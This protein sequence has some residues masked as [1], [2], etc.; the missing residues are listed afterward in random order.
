M[1]YDS[2]RFLTALQNYQRE[3]GYTQTSLSYLLGFSRQHVHKWLTGK[4][5]V[6]DKSI[7]RICK[8]IG[9]RVSRFLP[10][11]VTTKLTS[12]PDDLDEQQALYTKYHENSRKHFHD[13]HKIIHLAAF[14]T[15][16]RLI[17]NNMVGQ[18]QSLSPTEYTVTMSEYQKMFIS[19]LQKGIWITYNDINSGDTVSYSDLLTT[20]YLNFLITKINYAYKT[21]HNI[22]KLPSKQLPDSR[23]MVRPIQR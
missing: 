23:D 6:Q 20:E 15:F 2:K 22:S 1:R 17:E 16:H 7:E 18:I 21:K 3:R 11:G 14:T 5:C 8:L 13:I 10:K 4:T 12:Y 9:W 19:G